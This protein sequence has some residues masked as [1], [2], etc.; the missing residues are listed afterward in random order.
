MAPMTYYLGK[1]TLKNRGISCS[2]VMRSRF[3]FCTPSISFLIFALLLSPLL[4]LTQIRGHIRSRLASLLPTTV[5]AFRFCRETTSV[6]PSLVDSRRIA[7]THAWR[8][9]QLIPFLFEQIILK[10]HHNGI[11][12]H[13]PTLAASEGHHETIGATGVYFEISPK[14]Y[15]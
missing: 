1:S 14:H 9:Q 4:V 12:T 11:R 3:V 6:L 15:F 13:G 8:S 5:R 10:S 2:S 7:P